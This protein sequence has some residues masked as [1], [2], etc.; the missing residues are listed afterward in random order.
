[1]CSLELDKSN[2]IVK[3]DKGKTLIHRSFKEG[4]HL[5]CKEIWESFETIETSDESK[6]FIS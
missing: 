4:R 6:E 1:M 2:T 3:V 5:F